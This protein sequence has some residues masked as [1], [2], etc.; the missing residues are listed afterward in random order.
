MERFARSSA[1][2]RDR[3]SDA[4]LAAG[5][6]GTEGAAVGPRVLAGLRIVIVTLTSA[7]VAELETYS[8][9]IP[10][11]TPHTQGAQQ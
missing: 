3:V 8:A 2:V 7:T 6:R 9:V 5:A 4:S 1:R 10:P 11:M